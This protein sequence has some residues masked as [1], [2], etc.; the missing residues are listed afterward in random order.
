MSRSYF[1]EPESP[2]WREAWAALVAEFN[3]PACRN[4]H[5]GESWQY[6]GTEERGHCFRHR[7][8]GDA[9][10]YTYRWYPASPDASP[11]CDDPTVR[12]VTVTNAAGQ[13]IRVPADDY[14][15]AE[16]NRQEL[17]GLYAE[18]RRQQLEQQPVGERY[19]KLVLRSGREIRVPYADYLAA[20][21]ELDE[22]ERQD[23]KRE[24]G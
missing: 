16:R 18:R 10:G 5:T 4:P 8:L 12:F 6:M 24:G 1:A 20:E 11:V 23:A 21:A 7:Q 13:L 9:P 15:R 17:E 3:D 19:V 22:E 2:A 14:E